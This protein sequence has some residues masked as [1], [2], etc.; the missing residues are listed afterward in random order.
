MAYIRELPNGKYRVLWR[1]NA[2]DEFGSPIKGQYRQRCETVADAK[3]A[4][5]RRIAIEDQIER[6]DSPASQ[7]AKAGTPLGEYA[8]RYFDGAESRIGSV[9]LNGYRN[10]YRRHIADRFGGRPVGSILP[11]DVSSWF[12]DLLAG[13]S[14]RYTP[15]SD[16]EAPEFAKR[17]PKTAKQ[18]LGVLRRI[19][20]VAVLDSA[21][22]ANPALVKLTTSSK[23]NGRRRFKHCPLTPAQIATLADYIATEQHNPIYALLVTFTGFTGLRAAEVAGL[24]IGDLVLSEI[25]GTAGSVRVER[26]KTKTRDKT[27]QMVWPAEPTKTD[28]SARVVPVEAWLADDLR[29]YL[30]THPSTGD[31][32]APL[33]PGRMTLTEAKAQ[34]RNVKDSADRFDWSK[35]V[36]LNNFYKRFM[37]PAL[38][39][40]NLPAARFHDLRHSFAVNLLSAS[41]PVD[42]KRVSKWLGHSTFTLTLDV[43][44]DYINEDVS[45]PAGMTRPVAAPASNVIRFAR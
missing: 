28:E 45:K 9:T 12:S 17:D 44:G 42:F 16:P 3:A 15:D 34:G 14:N 21:I 18:A 20:N 35:P 37:Q 2:T 30:R 23:R 41:P 11:S 10:I 25:P 31:A 1:E 6:S 32:R 8:K 7:R 22:T 29:D 38:V 26:T 24:E 43:Y 4:E 33:F 27:G 40:L 19:C 36:D 39:A 5:R 13:E